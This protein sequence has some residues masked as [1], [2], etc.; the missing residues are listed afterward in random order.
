MSLEDKNKEIPNNGKNPRKRNLTI[1]EKIVLFE[2]Y[3]KETN[4][5]GKIIA[6]TVYE[7]YPI[8]GYLTIIRSE[9]N[10]EKTAKKYSQEEVGKLRGLGLLDKK[11][12]TINE[13]ADRLERFV[14]NNSELWRLNTG[15]D[16]NESIS[17]YIALTGKEEDREQLSQLL[18]EAN[19]DY[20][21]I[22]ARK[23]QG[24]V[25]DEIIK[26]LK[27][28]GVGRVFKENTDQ[29]IDEIVEKYEIEESKKHENTE[30]FR[31]QLIRDMRRFKNLDSFRKE[32]I[33]A[34]IEGKRLLKN[35]EEE[36]FYVTNFDLTQPDMVNRDDYYINVL[37]EVFFAAKSSNRKKSDLKTGFIITDEIKEIIDFEL[38]NGKFKEN[39]R[40]LIKLRCGYNN[41]EPKTLEKIA[42]S[43][44]T[45]KS[46]V[47][48]SATN[49]FKKCKNIAGL[50]EYFEKSK[51]K[52]EDFIR[53]YFKRHDIFDA[54][55][56]KEF[57]EADREKLENIIGTMSIKDR[58]E[59]KKIEREE[60]S[61]LLMIDEMG[62]NSNIYQALKR[63]QLNTLYDLTTKLSD[64]VKQIEGVTKSGFDRVRLKLKS[65]GYYFSEEVKTE[66]LEIQNLCIKDVIEGKPFEIKK[67]NTLQE[68]KQDEK[69]DEQEI[70]DDLPKTPIEELDLS[71]RAYN[72]LKRLGIDTVE[73]LKSKSED[74]TMQTGLTKKC[75]EEAI[76]KMHSMELDFSSEDEETKLE[77]MIENQLQDIA[78]QEQKTD[79]NGVN[80]E[81]IENAENAENIEKQKLIQKI[82]EQ[83]KIIA[84]QQK[85]IEELKKQK[86]K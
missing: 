66:E 32:Y 44:G 71:V 51:E 55:D 27:S 22:R 49:A 25:S 75:F 29:Y 4:G 21:Y 54:S 52:R 50:Y 18:K 9:L 61:K 6:N 57:S 41:G 43:F 74:E 8:G 13:R 16:I 19:E 81:N 79:E 47:G 76:E 34:L 20:D 3:I 69:Q 67:R 80:A 28:A 85:E 23:S 26:R 46:N 1:E 15:R 14:Q 72:R 11:K 31:N 48:Q 12:M 78:N 64:E 38:E 83:Q 42:E 10:R 65:L 40:K 30:V 2:R 24:K 82:L 5:E 36:K 62:F 35:S 39:E 84:E 77:D 33:Q 63:E 58:I 53:E 59:A 60:N 70:D 7:G 45:S 73:Q 86:L 17:E 37:K 56:V 68:E